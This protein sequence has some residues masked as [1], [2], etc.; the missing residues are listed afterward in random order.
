MAL[1]HQSLRDDLNIIRDDI[2]RSADTAD[3]ARKSVTG[4]GN[5]VVEA[6]R[7]IENRLDTLQDRMEELGNRADE[8]SRDIEVSE[9]NRLRATLERVSKSQRLL[10][11]RLS[12]EI[13]FNLERARMADTS[14]KGFANRMEALSEQLNALGRD[15]SELSSSV[16]ALKQVTPAPPVAAPQVAQTITGSDTGASP[17]ETGSQPRKSSADGLID[18]SNI[19]PSAEHANQLDCPNDEAA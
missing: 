3:S 7:R 13:R 12:D 9:I 2:A 10:E 19:G 15:Y 16:G 14:S 5:A 11:E 8:Q 18:Q 17:T 1:E 4:I 6:I